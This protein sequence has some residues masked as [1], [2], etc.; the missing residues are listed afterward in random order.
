[1]TVTPVAAGSVTL[2]VNFK[3]DGSVKASASVEFKVISNPLQL[4]WS[5]AGAP[6]YVA[7]RGLLEPG[8]LEMESAGV[9]YEV[10]SGADKV[11]L[12]QS[13]KN[14]YV[15]L[16]APGSYSIRATASNGQTGTFSG[17]VSAPVLTASTATL[18][19]NPDGSWAHTGTDGLTGEVLSTGYKGG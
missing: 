7:Q 19:A 6:V 2:T 10:L 4:G 14:T 17:S 15:E 1:M 16:V 3:V 18:Y 5:S 12:V 11:N 13:G 9:S 8:G